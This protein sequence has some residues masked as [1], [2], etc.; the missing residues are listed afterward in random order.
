MPSDGTLKVQKAGD[1]I[2]L[3]DLMLAGK[4]QE[5]ASRPVLWASLHQRFHSLW[6]SVRMQFLRLEAM[7]S[8]V[9]TWERMVTP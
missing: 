6:F 3:G 8:R 5:R 9:E 1:I 7:I 4:E 2:W